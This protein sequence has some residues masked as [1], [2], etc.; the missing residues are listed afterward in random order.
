MYLRLLSVM[1]VLV[2]LLQPCARSASAMV[3]QAPPRER[4]TFASALQNVRAFFIANVDQLAEEVRYYLPGGERSIYLT[5]DAIWVTARQAPSSL[6]TGG[7]VAADGGV[8]LRLSFP[9]AA[10]H[11][12]LQP[13]ERLETSVNYFIGDDPARWRTNV[14]VYGGVRYVGLYRGVDLEV[15]ADAGRWEMRLVVQPGADLNAV[16]LRI[17]GA[18]G[19]EWVEEGVLRVRTAAGDY[20]L[21]LMALSGGDAPPG[22]GVAAPRVFP[23]AGG[24]S[25]YEVA[26]PFGVAAAAR[27]TAAQGAADLAYA[28][29]LGGG[30]EDWGI[31]IA[32]DASGAAYVTGRTWSSDFPITAGA[33]DRSY[34]GDTD[35]FV[36]KLT[37]EAGGGPFSGTIAPMYPAAHTTP[38]QIMQGGTAYRYFRLL[39][40]HGNP[41]ANATVT[42]SAGNPATT[43]AQGYFTY[44]ILADALGN[45]GSYPISIRSVII[46]G[47]TYTTDNQPTFGVEVHERRYT[48]SWSYGA[49]RTASAGV[50]TGLIAYL[51]AETNG[52]LVLTL[53]ER[54]PRPHR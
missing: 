32:V 19:V 12:I 47:Q 49:L 37:T 34:S 7:A 41:I 39:D 52:G 13:L 24:V 33:Y 6:S 46:G 50:G 9:G 38:T 45:P 14:P 31:G 23:I 20:R 2:T 44:T 5:E 3:E 29:F 21:P 51:G 48:Y 54:Q 42:F 36:V 27:A 18:E 11:P 8:A 1:L 15:R 10:S 22:D 17:E 30:N 35:A 16:R 26:H 28:T 25:G 43:D 40:S 4:A 53:E